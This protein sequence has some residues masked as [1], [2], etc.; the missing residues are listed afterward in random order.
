MGMV[1]LDGPPLLTRAA[2]YK[3]PAL[4]LWEM[5]V[6]SRGKALYFY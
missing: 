2:I 5:P 3:K 4:S 1:L 6:I